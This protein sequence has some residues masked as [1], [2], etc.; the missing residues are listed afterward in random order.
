MILAVGTDILDVGRMERE[1][2]RKDPGLKS[3]VFTPR[4]IRYCEQKRYPARHFAARFAAKEAFLKA[5]G[6]GLSGE[7]RWQEIE[8]QRNSHGQPRIALSGKT[9]TFADRLGVR[10]IRVSLSH[11]ATMA[12]ATVILEQSSASPISTRRKK[13]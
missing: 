4:E 2:A 13:E 11:T 10:Q 6:T 12:A 9:R 3:R 8:V 1:L 7:L 5:I